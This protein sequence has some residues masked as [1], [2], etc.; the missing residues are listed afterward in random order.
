MYN[1]WVV[2]PLRDARPGASGRKIT[3]PMGR[4]VGTA[5]ETSVV[6]IVEKGTSEIVTAY[7]VK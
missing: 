6:L 4:V 2:V 1:D 5:G 3:V 7:P